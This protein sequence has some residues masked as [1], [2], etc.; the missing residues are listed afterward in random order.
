[1]RSERTKICIKR[2][3]RY[4][5]LSWF[6]CFGLFIGLL[7]YGFATK[8]VDNGS[9][10]SQ[11]IKAILLIW[12]MTLLPLLLIS[13]LVKDKAKPTIRMINVILS[14]YLVANWFMYVVGVFMLIDTYLISG[15]INKY[16]TAVIANKEIDLRDESNI[17]RKEN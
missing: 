14:A 11:H 10:V 9:E 12:T 8:W 16:K 6:L 15:L 2:K 1:M 5:F 13:F 17:I 3:R 7:V 4:L